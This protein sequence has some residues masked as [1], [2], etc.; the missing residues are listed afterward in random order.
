MNIK[1]N[2][3]T[4]LSKYKWSEKV[5]ININPDKFWIFINIKLK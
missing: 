4:F 1:N 3:R 5:M 2:L